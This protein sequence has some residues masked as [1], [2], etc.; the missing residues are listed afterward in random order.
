[1][2]RLLVLIALAGAAG[3]RSQANTSAQAHAAGS[4]ARM[5]GWRKLGDWSGTGSLQT[6]SF[7]TATGQLR[8]RWRAAPAAGTPSS[9]LR[10]PFRVSANSAISGRTL[11]VAVDSPAP[12]SGTAA[13]SIEPHEMYLVIEAPNLEWSVSVEEAVS[14]TPAQ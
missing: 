8:V 2:K 10:R 1:V 12:G 3:C 5:I 6:P 4:A 9:G 11:E 7:E 14:G 13:V